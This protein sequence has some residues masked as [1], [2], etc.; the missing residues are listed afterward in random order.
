MEFLKSL[1]QIVAKEAET[2]MLNEISQK[3]YWSVSGKHNVS[4]KVKNAVQLNAKKVASGEI[5]VEEAEA[6]IEWVKGL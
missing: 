2:K 1:Q 3:L 5:S 6:I 4:E